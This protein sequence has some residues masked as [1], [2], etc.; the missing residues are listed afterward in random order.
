[1]GNI[2]NQLAGNVASCARRMDTFYVRGV[3]TGSYLKVAAKMG[4]TMHSP[5]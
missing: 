4:S 1:M 2:G 3:G 5:P